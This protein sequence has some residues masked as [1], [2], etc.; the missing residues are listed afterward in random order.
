[1][2]IDNFRATKVD[3]SCNWM[4]VEFGDDNKEDGSSIGCDQK[5]GEKRRRYVPVPG[6][7]FPGIL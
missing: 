1:M 6:E 4:T 3:A 7:A 5:T 2:D